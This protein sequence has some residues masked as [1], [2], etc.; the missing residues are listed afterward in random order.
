MLDLFLIKKR[1]VKKI[2]LFIILLFFI[3]GFSQSNIEKIQDYLNSNYTRW[4]ITNQD[5]LDWRIESK[6]TSKSTKIDNYYIK[7]QY[8]EI[9]IF[10]AVSNVWIKNDKVINVSNRFVG[11]LN[12]KINTTTPTLSVLDALLSAKSK[13]DIPNSEKHS[14]IEAIDSKNFKISNGNLDVITAKLVYQ[15]KNTFLRLA[16]D[17]KIDVPS[18]NHLWSV[19]IDAVTGELLDNNDLVIS[20]SFDQTKHLDSDKNYFFNPFEKKINKSILDVQ[21]GSYRVVPYNIE[22]PNHGAR[23][24]VISPSNALASPF[25]WH[26]TNGVIGAEFTITKGNNV[27]A[28]EDLDDDDV[29]GLSPNGGPSLVFDFPYQ[30]IN[31]PAINYLDA[32]TTNLFY[33]NNVIHDVFYIHGF[34]EENGNF[35]FNNYGNGGE[36]NDHVLAQAQDGGGIN[37]AN[38]GTPPDGGNGRMQ[39]YLWNRRPTANLI[40]VNSPLSI[41]GNYTALDNNFIEGHVNLPIAPANISA[42]LVLFDDGVPVNSDAC[43]PAINASAI[44]GKI[45]VIRRGICTAPAKVIEAQNA[46]AI[47]AIVV[48]NLP[49]N[50]YMGGVNNAITIPAIS[51]TQAVGELLIT[52]MLS[53]TVNVNLSLPLASD[54]VNT[55]CDFDNLVITHEYGH[56]ISNRLTGGSFNGDCLNNQ[57]Q[58]GEGWSDWFGLIMQMKSGESGVERRGVG[59]FVSNQSTTDVGIRTYPY[60]TDMS[61]N[62]FTFASTNTLARPHGVGSVWATMLWDLAWAY[63]NKYGFNPNIYTGNGGNNK[64]LQIVVDALKLQPCNPSFV[65]G[66]DAIIAADQAI[67]GGQDFCLI[68]DVFARRGLGVNA[69]SG[70]GDVSTDQIEN[71]TVPSPGPNC[72]LEIDYFQNED[73]ISIFPNPANES[74]NIK[75]N[76][77]IGKISLQLFDINGRIILEEINRDFSLEE[78]ISITNLSTGIYIL[79]LSAEN[80]NFTKKIIVN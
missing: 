29:E 17:F 59:T 62:P 70:D 69:S 23:Q 45:A 9:E 8:Q 43:E 54:F 42:N 27:S 76:N 49:N 58:M 10:G 36:E 7:Q 31:A 35:Q 51:V 48:N 32:A 4:K 25:G 26:D 77:Y 6:A 67:T 34:D 28:F 20:C 53:N 66:R 78:N 40:T 41:A 3:D 68:W 18:H 47:A 13:L 73:V 22:S 37:N 64:V 38:F 55:D 15:K 60:T 24:L 52:Q 30:G 71:F 50:Y 44:N 72:N 5:V 12:Q 14:I 75:I 79:K 2:T 61:I 65:E 80:I 11:N 1:T 63:V 19:R 39:M 74:F 16:W 46:G 57:E 56:G 33:I 21:S